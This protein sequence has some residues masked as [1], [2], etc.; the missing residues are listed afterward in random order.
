ME[1]RYTVGTGGD[2]RGVLVPLE[3]AAGFG[4]PLGA[5]ALTVVL[6]VRGAEAAVGVAAAVTETTGL[7]T[8]AAIL[9]STAHHGHLPRDEW[10]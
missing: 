1:L 5:L 8:M 3:T 9:S 7:P 6:A 2:V 10:N 4:A